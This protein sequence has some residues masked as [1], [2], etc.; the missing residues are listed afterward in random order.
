M[1]L[2]SSQTTGPSLTQ[3]ARVYRGQPTPDDSDG[4]FIGPCRTTAEIHQP[5]G[6]TDSNG[7]TR[8]GILYFEALWQTYEW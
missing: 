5:G 3:T 8:A 6:T 7:G 1:P 4:V 2:A